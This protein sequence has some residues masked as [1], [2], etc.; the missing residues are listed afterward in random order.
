MEAWA[1]MSSASCRERR[2][3]PRFRFT[4]LRVKPRAH[5]HTHKFPATRTDGLIC[6]PPVLAPPALLYV[7]QQTLVL[8]ANVAPSNCQSPDAAHRAPA[9]RH[10]MHDGDQG[11]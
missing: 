11:A 6:R 7:L 1:D 3:P 8:C 10:D 5:M 2:G 9:L 4:N